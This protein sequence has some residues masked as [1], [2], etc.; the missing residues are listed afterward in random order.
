MQI[1]LK[2]DLTGNPNSLFM[3]AYIARGSTTFPPVSVSRGE[4]MSLAIVPGLP[5]LLISPIFCCCCYQ[6]PSL[7]LLT[8]GVVNLIL[9]HKLW[10]FICTSGFAAW[11]F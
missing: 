7:W 4:P 6:I 11:H 1:S 10:I 8:F 9:Q 3:P 5:F 2:L